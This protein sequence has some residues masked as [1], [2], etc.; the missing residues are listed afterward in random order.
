MNRLYRSLTSLFLMLRLIIHIVV[1]AQ[2]LVATAV[3][4]AIGS[5]VLVAQDWTIGASKLEITPEGPVRLSG[6]AARNKPSAGIDS[7]LYVRSLFLKHK[8]GVPLLIVSLDA[9][10]ISANMTQEIGQAIEKEFGLSRAQVVL[11][12]THSHTA[13]HLHGVLTNLFADGLSPAELVACQRYTAR[14]IER[15]LQSIRDAIATTVPGSVSIS[16]DQADF[17]INRRV[18]QSGR[19]AN[20]GETPEGPV[21]RRVKVLSAHGSD[22]HLLAVAFQYA[23]HCT[24]ISPERNRISSD[25]AGMS[26]E[27]FETANRNAIALPIIGAGAD[28]NPNPRGEDSHALAHAKSMYEAVSRAVKSERKQLV[29]PTQVAFS[30]VG[31]EF[32]RPDVSTLRKLVEDPNK[33]V[34]NRAKGLLETLKIKDRIPES[35]PAPV[36]FWSF[37]D[38]LAWVFLG[39]E[40]VV[41]YQ[42]R[43][44]RELSQF[45]NVWVAAYVD[46]V[47]AYVASERLRREGGYEVDS[48]MV[49]YNQPGP[50]KSGTEEKLVLGVLDLQKQ[51]RDLDAPLDKEQALRSMQ[52]PDGFRIEQLA[53]ESLVMDPINFSFDIDGKVW[54]L[55]MPDYPNGG[56]RSGRIICLEDL[57]RDG[58][59]ETATPFMSDLP[60]VSG[61]Y[62]WRDGVVVACA[63]EVFFARDTDQDGIADEKRVILSGF[64]LAN[65]QHRVHGFTYGLDHK[66]HFGAGS[67]T[68]SVQLHRLDGTKQEFDI[69]GCDLAI[70]PDRHELSLESGETQFIR[71]HDGWGNWF[72]ND[73]T[74]PI[75]HYV[76]DRN[77]GS[78]GGRVA[79]GMVRFL[80]KPVDSPIVY[81][82]SSAL[83]RFNDPLTANRYTS[84][85]ST[86]L[87]LSS[88]NGESMMGQA[89][90]CEPVH[91]LV[92][93]LSMVRDGISW[94]AERFTEDSTRE[95]LRS[96]DPWFRPVRVANAPDGS[97]WVADMYRRVIEHP[98]WIPEEWLARLNVY[99]GQDHGR[100]YR[101]YHE[102]KPPRN[103]GSPLER[104]DEELISHLGSDNI[105]L[106]DWAQQ[107]LIWRS[108]A[109]PSIRVLLERALSSASPQVRLRAFA[110]LRYLGHASEEH[111]T[112][113]LDDKDERLV[114]YV[115]S[116]LL[117]EKEISNRM[118]E[119][120][121][122]RLSTNS[123]P[124]PH[125]AL[126]MILCFLN[127]GSDGDEQRIE[128]CCD[129]LLENAEVGG[130][131]L[132]F[133]F[134][135][136]DRLSTLV[137]ELIRRD[138][139]RGAVYLNR[140]IP[141]LDSKQFLGIVGQIAGHDGARPAWHFFMIR[142]LGLMSGGP[143]GLNELADKVYFE[144]KKVLRDRDQ[145]L[146]VRKA[147]WEL[148]LSRIS[149]DS[150]DEV[151]QLLELVAEDVDP[152]MAEMIVAGLF[153]LG[154]NSRRNLLEASN[155]WSKT[156][157]SVVFSHF[158][159]TQ[160]GI[161]RLLEEIR[162]GRLHPNDV[163]PSQV[164]IIRQNATK[165]MLEQIIAAWGRDDTSAR[166]ESLA[167]FERE[168]PVKV[169]HELGKALFEVHCAKC[170]RAT[171]IDGLAGVSI[172]PS[173]QSLSHWTNRAWLEAI[174]DPSRAV[175][176]RYKR[177]VIRTSD[178]FVWSGLKRQ[179][180]DTDLELVLTD[181]RVEKIL[182]SDIEE[183][184]GS[185]LSLMPDGFE[186][187]L[188]PEQIA[189]IVTYLRRGGD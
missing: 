30:Y 98:T 48:S 124:D 115:L 122:R 138:D 64:A 27:M 178:D 36:H 102:S 24:S 106:A 126:R 46:D 128:R 169:D 183:T 133:E 39:G 35:Y 137:A 149:D 60:F 146:A 100:L 109:S 75:Y 165:E 147:A 68:S 84:V 154:D 96:S 57:D 78:Q 89:I 5:T 79:S 31:L 73:N 155:G 22:G 184:K 136:S 33:H 9:I 127:H 87:N 163:S 174:I 176:D 107:Q 1:R 66:L 63:P 150:S 69:R 76:Y 110:I 120:I 188:T 145:S 119:S 182:K 121:S 49:Y 94:R 51:S 16:E 71:S 43:L 116:C 132:I 170:H 14:V 101:V 142:Q 103:P 2:W 34:Q 45:T 144:A 112:T 61:V 53:A 114:S 187:L 52:V 41:D 37:G 29:A 59:F 15:T 153:R 8:E 108:T 72:G 23:C 186:K 95:W 80:T 19:W 90:V 17:A 134:A 180:T 38:Q 40:V 131:E 47:F 173:L 125:L 18:I 171:M 20:F 181:G 130:F 129:L 92:S 91:N 162:L 167:R 21:D 62:A 11:C 152:T 50:W 65:P 28:S 175:E 55:E 93:R 70:D 74:H 118:V 172:G 160:N 168:W 135:K 42:I 185:D 151:K 7:P 12:T 123:K 166:M 13:P 164:E 3:C 67:D 117:R 32:D 158:V 159:S 140:L 156:L 105:V 85:C 161:S 81:P 54:V 179:E 177:S 86:I 97:I 44:E 83:D 189:Q 113:L 111:I 82:L 56:A 58:S 25:W 88:G 4:F 104:T 139:S 10:G 157:R 141:K 99:A 6:Y 148:H 77:W 143:T 26:A